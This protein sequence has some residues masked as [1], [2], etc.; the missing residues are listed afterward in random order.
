MEQSKKKMITRT[1]HQYQQAAEQ[2][3]A[4]AQY[5][6]GL[7]YKQG[8]GVPQDDAL[9][10][11]W[12]RKAAEQGQAGAQNQLGLLY[13]RDAASPAD[14]L[15]VGVEQGHLQAQE[16]LKL[17]PPVPMS[18]RRLFLILSSIGLASSFLTLSAC[19]KDCDDRDKDCQNRGGGS[20][21]WFRGRGG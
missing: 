14:A 1:F 18:N 2:G 13:K 9:A 17:M 4:Q 15:A 7:I 6:L 21:W 5:Q 19:G 12:F 11:H 8:K 20:Y 10:I 16:S 3:Q